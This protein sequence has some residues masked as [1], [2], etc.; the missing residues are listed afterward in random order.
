VL[1]LVLAVGLSLYIVLQP[2]GGARLAGA[3]GAAGNAASGYTYTLECGTIRL[4]NFQSIKGLGTTTEVV[5]RQAV[6]TGGRQT[7][8]LVAG[9]LKFSPLVL[10]RTLTSDTNAWNWRRQVAES[11]K[12]DAAQQDCTLTV[13]D[14]KSNMLAQWGLVNAWPSAYMV[15]TATE[16]D[17]TAGV[18]TETLTIVYEVL[19]RRK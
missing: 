15:D 19:N 3:A 7:V 12:P 9:Q 18:P 17:A 13:Y 5:E 1:I 8:Q 11:N 6:D 10:K 4:P 16:T 14:G 2:I